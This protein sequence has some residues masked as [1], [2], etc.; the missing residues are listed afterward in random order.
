MT[1]IYCCFANYKLL[2]EN[3]LVAANVSSL[4]TESPVVL[5]LKGVALM[6]SYFSTM[7]MFEPTSMS[8][9]QREFIAA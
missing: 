7:R 6:L 8:G 9:M 5:R 2:F 4:Y 3:L 1:N